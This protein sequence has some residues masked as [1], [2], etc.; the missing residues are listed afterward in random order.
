[1]S[2]SEESKRGGVSYQNKDILFKVLSEAYREKSFAAYGIDLPRIKAVLPTNLPKIWANVKEP[3]GLF[4]LEDDTYVIVDYESEYRRENMVKY[5]GYAARVIE[6]HCGSRRKEIWLRLIVVYT[7]DVTTAESVMDVGCL[8]LRIE[9]VFLS[10]LDGEGEY[11][12]IRKILKEGRP[13]RDEDVMRL[14]ILPLTQR[15][16]EKKRRMVEDV[17]NLT[18]SFQDNGQR[19]FVLS[20]IMVASDKFIEARYLEK[21]RRSVEMTKFGQMIY[22]EKIAYGKEVAKKAAR[23]ATREAVVGCARSMLEM[24]VD[25]PIIMKV[26]RLSEGEIMSLQS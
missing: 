14:V 3:D 7:G 23:E 16:K 2:E 19:N 10:N 9:Q 8:T 26:T 11:A 21:I 20:G 5:L 17:V 15:G 24:G 25:A 18:E 6:K 13:L 22:D 4:L 12:R 1:M